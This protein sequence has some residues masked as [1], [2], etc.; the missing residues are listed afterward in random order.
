MATLIPHVN[1]AF[2]TQ[3]ERRFYDFLKQAAKPD[4]HCYAW[5][6]PQIEEREPDFVL[7]T[8][9]VGLV[10]FEVKD[11]VISQVISADPKTFRLQFAGNRKESRTNPFFQSRGY[12]FSILNKIKAAGSLLI[13][14]EIGWKF[15]TP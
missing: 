5:Y 13:S 11:W 14:S 8:P 6:S 15:R 4:S 10:V 7:Y 1:T 3:G 9:E 2:T 12:T